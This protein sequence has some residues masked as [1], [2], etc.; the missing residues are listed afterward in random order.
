LANLW[1]NH[2]LTVLSRYRAKPISKT[3]TA[4]KKSRKGSS[5]VYFARGR[6]IGEHMFCQWSV[7]VG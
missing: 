4:P 2:T 6:R 5:R 7:H 3:V 1:Y